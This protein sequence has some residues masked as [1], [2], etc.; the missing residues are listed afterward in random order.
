MTYTDL[1]NA[2]KELRANGHELQIKLNAKK[3]ALQ[4]EYDR[5]TTEI[6]QEKV[7]LEAS[8]HFDEVETPAQSEVTTLKIEKIE[9][10][11][12][13][14]VTAEYIADNQPEYWQQWDTAYTRAIALLTPKT[15]TL[16]TSTPAPVPTVGVIALTVFALFIDA[17]VWC[18]RTAIKSQALRGAVASFGDMVRLTVGSRKRSKAYGFAS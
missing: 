4:A 3:D 2:L 8:E 10:V 13:R 18:V 14:D 9:L 15:S 7:L 6:K 5:I 17:S 1:Q 12:E 11:T 16:P